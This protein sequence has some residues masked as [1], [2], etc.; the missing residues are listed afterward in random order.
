MARTL[1]LDIGGVF[2]LS[3]PDDAFWSRW[4]ERAKCDADTLRN[5]FW[6]NPSA[7]DVG[8]GRLPRRHF[9][10]QMATRYDMTP[11]AIESMFQEVF[12]GN[13]NR[14]FADFVRGLRARGVAVSSLTNNWSTEEELKARPELAGLFDTVI[15][16]CE[17]GFLKPGPEIYRCALERLGQSSHE[18]VFVD[19]ARVC[20]DAATAFGMTGIHFRQTARAMAEIEAC[21]A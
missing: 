1:L 13:F 2:Y 5:D 19:D 8:I 11:D 20:I 21:L 6:N 17:A 16:S 4:A 15:S 14:E 7:V 18:I 3:R 10:A 12:T 9:Y